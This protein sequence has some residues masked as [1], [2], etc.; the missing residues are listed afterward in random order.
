MI[1]R[2]FSAYA[3]APPVGR[4][5]LRLVL[6][7]HCRTGRWS[8]SSAMGARCIRARHCGP[9]RMIVSLSRL[10]FSITSHIGFSSSGFIWL[11]ETP[12]GWTAIWGWSYSRNNF[13]QTLSVNTLAPFRLGWMV[14]QAMKLPEGRGGSIV[15]VTS[16]GAHLGFPD[17]PAYQASKAA[18][19]QITRAMAVDFGT[20]GVRVNNICPGYM[21]TAMSS[22]SY[23]DPEAKE[24]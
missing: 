18:L 13:W 20:Q 1:L 21:V 8:R 12:L 3:A 11:R 19:R 16:L 24:A 9:L 22:A 15:N 23:N 2:V 4:Y 10:L 5:Q 7:L 17:N 14:A 6:N